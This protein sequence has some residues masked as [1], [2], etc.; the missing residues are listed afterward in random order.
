M[1]G[2]LDQS[3]DEILS[4]TRRT[5]VGKGRRVGGRRAVAKPAHI[6]PSGGVKKAARGG[7]VTAQRTPTGPSGTGESKILVTGLVRIPESSLTAPG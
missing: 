4:S 7:K 3:L 6:A 1:S 5:S 2:K